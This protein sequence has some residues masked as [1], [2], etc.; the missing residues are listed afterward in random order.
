MRGGETAQKHPRNKSETI[1]K[2]ERG[3]GGGGGTLAPE[4]KSP[5]RTITIKRENTSKYR[6]QNNRQ[7]E[8]KIIQRIK[9]NQEHTQSVCGTILNLKMKI[10]SLDCKTGG[11]L[12]SASAD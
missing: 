6:I 1:S 7:R 5:R 11:R 9:I 8:S 10:L 2:K 4:P 3:V 12:G